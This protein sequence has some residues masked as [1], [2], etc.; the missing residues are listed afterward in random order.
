MRKYIS[1]CVLF[2]CCF[3]FV[4]AGDEEQYAVSKIP[5]RL[6]KKANAVLRFEEL[7]FELQNSQ[8]A[9]FTNHYVITILNENGEDWAQM[10]DYYDKDRRIENI[11]GALY[12]ADGKLI[13]KLK[14]KEVQDVSGVDDN[15]LIDDNRIKQHNFYHKVFPYTIEYEIVVKY[16]STL[17]FPGWVPQGSDHLS[18]VKSSVIYIVPENYKLRY[19]A[20]NY[21]GEPTVASEKG[22]KIYTWSAADMPALEKEAYAPDWHEIT[23]YVSFAPSEFQVDDYKGNMNSWQDFGKFV[24]VLKEGRDELPNELKNKIHQLT[25]GLTDPKKKIQVL[26]EFMQKNTRYISIQLGI[27][28]WQPF[29]AGFVASKGYGDCKALTNYMYSILKESGLP[30]YYTII[31]AGAGRGRIS[32]D[33][34]SQQFNHVILCVPLERDTVWL[35][36]TSQTLPAGYLSEFTS[37]RY[38]LMIDASG[39]KLVRTPKYGLKENIQLRKLNAKLD[40]EGILSVKANTTYAA[41]QQ[42]MLHGMIHALAKDKQKEYLQKQLDFAT[43]DINGFEYAENKSSLPIINEKLEITVHNYA[44]ITGKRLFIIPNIMSRTVQRQ[45]AD[46][47]RK[48]DLVLKNEFQHIDSAEIELPAGYEI[49]SAP[50]DISITT[51]FG[52]YF[53]SV[54][55]NGNRLSYYRLFQRY[56]GRF[57]PGEYKEWVSFNDAMYKADNNKVV[58]LKKE[59]PPK[60]F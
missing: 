49:E 1:L 2:L 4:L 3:N 45:K 15:N 19:R 12:G 26:Y 30:S 7:K 5:E 31:R 28:G 25:G 56:S 44:S 40:E 53:C 29:A 16:K 35:E 51:K 37:D 9:V 27:G 23:T 46:Q 48:Y 43:Y 33:F 50:Q 47:E 11:D 58:L 10:A 21:P 42:D 34:P 17:F 39:G 22:K 24:Y 55:L 6:L 18:V 14:N 54:K 38:A 60:P 41:M 8:E 57:T 52:K 36:C 20:W 13:R 59:G 32:D